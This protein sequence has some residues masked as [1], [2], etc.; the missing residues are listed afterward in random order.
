MSGSLLPTISFSGVNTP[1]WAYS[2]SGGGGGGGSNY[3]ADAQFSSITIQQ[4][5]TL[6]SNI[7]MGPALIGSHIYMNNNSL[8]LS[9]N[10]N[11]NLVTNYNDNITYLTG[12][13]T[14]GVYVGT[15]TNLDVLQVTDSNVKI[16]GSLQ[17]PELISVSTINGSAYP[18]AGGGGYTATTLNWLNG[19]SNQLPPSMPSSV[20]LTNSTAPLVNGHTYRVTASFGLSNLG[21]TGATSLFLEGT[22]TPAGGLPAVLYQDNNVTTVGATPYYGNT[23][24]FTCAGGGATGFVITGINSGT[25]AVD[26]LSDQG[27]VI[28]EDMGVVP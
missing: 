22:S 16:K 12:L 26:V 6:T 24:Y 11:A 20:P 19:G 1:I 28:V 8:Y 23:T 3:P 4:G 21:S 13:S 17:A 25:S 2:G 27:F 15:Q 18:P 10:T 7:T 9:S 5:I 14:T